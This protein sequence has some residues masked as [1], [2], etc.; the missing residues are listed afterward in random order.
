VRELTLPEGVVAKDEPDAVVVQVVQKVDEEAVAAPA[1]EI[2][3][4]EV[5]G[6]KVEEEVEEEK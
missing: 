1:G 2:A 5:I 4:P 3:E 6:R